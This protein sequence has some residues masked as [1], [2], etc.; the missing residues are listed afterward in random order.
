MKHTTKH[1]KHTKEK[2]ERFNFFS[3]VSCLSWFFRVS[4]HRLE[5]NGTVLVIVRG[6]AAGSRY[7]G[8][9]KVSR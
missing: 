3:C 4:P 2:E 1:T 7:E 5:D 8:W 9:F 6:A